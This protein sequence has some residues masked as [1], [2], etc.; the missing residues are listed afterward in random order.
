ME[1]DSVLYELWHFPRGAGIG[2][3][4]QTLCDTRGHRAQYWDLKDAQ[5]SLEAFIAVESPPDPRNYRIVRI[6]VEILC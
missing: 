6:T 1:S 2:M 4:S 3:P 5:G